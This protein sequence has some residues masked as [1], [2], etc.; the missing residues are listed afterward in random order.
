V[1]ILLIELEKLFRVTQF[2]VRV[3]PFGLHMLQVVDINH[4]FHCQ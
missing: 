2:I 3:F 1:E 4:E